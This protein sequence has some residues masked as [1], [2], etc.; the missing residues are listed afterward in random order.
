MKTHTSLLKALRL[1]L[2]CAAA[3]FAQQGAPQPAVLPFEL[4][5]NHILVLARVNASAPLWFIFDTGAGQTMLDLRSAKALHLKLG[6]SF[7]ARG[8]G[9]NT[10]SG[11]M[12]EAATLSLPEL[13]GFT[14]PLRMALSFESLEPME[15]RS[16][17]GVLGYDFIRRFVV[18]VD[19]SQRQ[20][21]LHDPQGLTYAGKGEVLPLTFKTNH[22]HVRATI[23]PVN[24]APMEV[25]CMLDLGARSALILTRPLVERH[26]LIENAPQT[27]T[28]LAGRSVG[29]DV[30]LLITRLKSFRLRSFGF[31]QP[32][33]G[34]S[35]DTQGALWR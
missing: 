33:T 9:A 6:H 4:A 13:P 24:G 1:L 17:N 22:P 11:V 8:A 35:Q 15:G 10:V 3:T 7:Q 32:I 14:H 28:A 23:E 30:H 31:K 18:E 20:L 2:L 12:L 5:N 27:L 25:D 26:K 19:F 16:V 29:G 34:L 21:R